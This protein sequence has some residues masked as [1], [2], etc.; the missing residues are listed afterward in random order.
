MKLASGLYEQLVTE[1]LQALLV[2][3]VPDVVELREDS[4]SDLLSRHMSD[5]NPRRGSAVPPRRR[6]RHRGGRFEDFR[7]AAHPRS[8]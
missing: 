4:A 1:E 3:R 7:V 2:D 8:A 6:L 5:G